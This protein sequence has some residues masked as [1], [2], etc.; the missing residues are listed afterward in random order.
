[1]KKTLVLASALALLFL[2]Q[3]NAEENENQAMN[4]VGVNVLHT[5]ILDVVST[6]LSDDVLY[7]PIH[8]SYARAFDK[9]WGLSALAFYRLDKDGDFRTNEFGLAVGPR[10]S[11]DYLEGFYFECKFGAGIAVG[12]DYLHNDYTRID[13]IIQPDIGYNLSL[14]DFFSISFGVGLQT[15]I[16]VSE[17]PSRSGVWDWNFMG[18][19]SHYY[20]PVA[21]LSACFMF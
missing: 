2:V 18:K 11:F 3:G 14:A 9:N 12:V 6:S 4:M 7:L 15:L 19:L 8:F 16:S 10:F 1:M 20:L 17:T 21:N 13:F 5:I